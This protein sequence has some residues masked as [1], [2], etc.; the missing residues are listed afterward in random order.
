MPKQDEYEINLARLACASQYFVASMI[1]AREMY[2]K[3]YF[4]LGVEEKQT[5]DQTVYRSIFG[6]LASITPASFPVPIQGQTG[7]QPPDVPQEP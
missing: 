2:G 3:S 6:N 7:F 5:L 4:S 1:A